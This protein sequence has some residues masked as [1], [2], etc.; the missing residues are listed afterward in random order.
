MLGRNADRRVG[1]DPDVR[2]EEMLMR[3]IVRAALGCSLLLSISLVGCTDEGVDSSIGV[4]V[5]A[6]DTYD[7]YQAA[8]AGRV[9]FSLSL[10]DNGNLVD[11][12]ARPVNDL[13][14]VPDH[15]VRMQ[16]RG[17]EIIDLVREPRDP[18]QDEWSQPIDLRHFDELGRPV[19]EATYQL[20]DVQMT[21]DGEISHHKALEVCWAASGFCTVMDPAVLQLSAFAKMRQELVAG[22]WQPISETPVGETFNLESG[23]RVAQVCSLNS[24]P[25]WGGITYTW[26]GFTVTY[27]NVFGVT[28]VSKY[29]AGQQVGVSCYISSG[30]CR[31]SG[32]GYS[33]ASSCSAT[34]GYNCSCAN[35]GNNW[36]TTQPATRSI[37]ETKCTHAFAGN[38]SISFSWKGT[39]G[40][41]SLVWNTNGSVD[42]SGGQV[43]DACSWH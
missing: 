37:S 35:S 21:L 11:I 38:T 22:G 14:G 19:A 43:Y 7:D 9:R 2:K 15:W 33:F 12:A 4:S 6:L 28:L 32:N 26:S 5:T 23:S 18:A 27:K 31:S 34:L 36:G 20:L 40:S 17:T 42:A 13:V 30:A 39:G 1:G 8:A 16:P 25:T 24:H 10:L 41:L 3:T 29:L